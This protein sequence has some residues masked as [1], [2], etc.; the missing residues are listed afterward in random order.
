MK[1]SRTVVATK[2]FTAGR[3]VGSRVWGMEWRLAGSDSLEFSTS[4]DDSR[5]NPGQIF[6]PPAVTCSGHDPA[7]NL[8]CDGIF[9]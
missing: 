5:H 2:T 3:L 7:V 4:F 1:L 9:V 8:G 6:K